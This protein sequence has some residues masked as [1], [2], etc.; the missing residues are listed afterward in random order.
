[1]RE[2]ALGRL[3]FQVEIGRD[4]LRQSVDALFELAPLYV[5]GAEARVEGVPI[6]GDAL[7]HER[8]ERLEVR[9]EPLDIL[10][11]ER[12]DAHLVA[13]LQASLD[14]R[15]L[16]RDAVPEL[17]ERGQQLLAMRLV[18]HGGG[19]AQ[20][21]Q[22]VRLDGKRA[23]RGRAADVRQR[24][25]R[26]HVGEDDRR[27]L[28]LRVQGPVAALLERVEDGAPEAPLHGRMDRGALLLDERL[29][30]R[31]QLLDAALHRHRE[32]GQDLVEL[33]QMERREVTGHRRAQLERADHA[34][35]VVQGRHH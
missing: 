34:V 27:Q 33:R 30:A 3:L 21:A 25:E 5:H 7:A 28:H 15:R 12:H 23:L 8:A 4:R 20:L 29:H 32:E 31:V 2:H 26:V 6:G 24:V 22:R 10:A 18:D 9:E 35:L 13:G 11:E 16:P 17:V 1:M 14:L 19:E